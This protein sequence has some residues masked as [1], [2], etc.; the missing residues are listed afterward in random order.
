MP[1]DSAWNSLAAC[2]VSRQLAAGRHARLVVTTT[3]MA[4]FLRPGDRVVVAAATS[5][6]LQRGDIVVAAALPRPLVHRLVAR[7]DDGA[8]LLLRTKGD[9]GLKCDRPLA[10]QTLVGRVVAVER[11]GRTLAL[12]AGS[13]RIAARGMATLSCCSAGA[14]CLRPRL[15]RCA[16]LLLLR[17]A[18]YAVA[19][20]AWSRS[21]TVAEGCA[22][23]CELWP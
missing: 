1:A 21:R 9:R 3:S 15:V 6:S 20:V 23:S 4:P 12:T 13:V 18:M 11:A 22:G 10:P 2:L 14:T 17:L 16:T 19:E 8:N 5:R 7:I